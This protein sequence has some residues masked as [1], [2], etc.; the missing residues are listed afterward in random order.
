MRRQYDEA[1]RRATNPIS[2]GN[3]SFITNVP[4]FLAHQSQ[5][6]WSLARERE[7][8]LFSHSGAQEGRCSSGQNSTVFDS[9]EERQQITTRDEIF[10]SH[11]SSRR[12]QTKA[13]IHSTLTQIRRPRTPNTWG[14]PD[15]TNTQNIEIGIEKQILVNTQ[16]FK[17]MRNQRSETSLHNRK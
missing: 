11:Y 17:T 1:R 6:R 12:H 4:P 14:S 9:R 16:L 7:R 8:S 2:V 3:Y 5:R 13:P 10:P 15:N